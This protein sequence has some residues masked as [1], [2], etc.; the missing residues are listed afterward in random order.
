MESLHKR[1]TATSACAV[2]PSLQQMNMLT[3]QPHLPDEQSKAALYNLCNTR[4][5]HIEADLR[6]L[7]SSCKHTENLKHFTPSILTGLGCLCH[8]L[9]NLGS[10]SLQFSS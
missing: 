7:N 3:L 8:V 6:R 10:S 1:R 4:E 2:T 5:G 9:D